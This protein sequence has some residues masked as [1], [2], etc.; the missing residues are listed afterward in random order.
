MTKSLVERLREGHCAPHAGCNNLTQCA[1]VAL[2]EAAARIEALE[3]ENAR[4]REGLSNAV[5][6]FE[7][8]QEILKRNLVEPERSAFW[9]AVSS[10]NDAR[11]ALAT[12]AAAEKE[13]TP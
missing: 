3:A 5:L 2:D 10:K 8:I 1:C 6:Q 4:L 12:L 7:Q 13:Q 9:L 11:Y